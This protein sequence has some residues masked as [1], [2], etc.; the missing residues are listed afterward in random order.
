MQA[1]CFPLGFRPDSAKLLQVSWLYLMG[2]KGGEREAGR[3]EGEE[4][5][6]GGKR[7]GGGGRD[8]AHPQILVWRPLWLWDQSSPW[9]VLYCRESHCLAMAMAFILLQ[10]TSI[11]CG[12]I[13]KHELN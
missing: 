9:T 10:Q 6:R 3:M 5:V 4:K 12:T 7:R 2:L 11:L 13:N 1:I 8:F